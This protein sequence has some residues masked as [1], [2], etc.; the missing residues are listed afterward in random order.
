MFRKIDYRARFCGA[1]DGNAALF[2]TSPRLHVASF[3][4][5][6]SLFL[7]VVLCRAPPRFIP[8]TFYLLV[9]IVQGDAGNE[10]TVVWVAVDGQWLMYCAP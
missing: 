4:L 2:L 3:S 1:G 6:I 10:A 9:M 7:P 5:P 8:G